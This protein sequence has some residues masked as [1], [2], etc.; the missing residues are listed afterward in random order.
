MECVKKKL[1]KFRKTISEF[2][3]VFSKQDVARWRSSLKDMEKA[4]DNFKNDMSSKANPSPPV[5]KEADHKEKEKS[6]NLK[7]KVQSIELEANDLEIFEALAKLPNVPTDSVFR[8]KNCEE[9]EDK[10]LILKIFNKTW[11]RIKSF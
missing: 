9:I 7:A 2:S 3:A 8:P 5:I 1:N 4:V 10:L 6:D 11:L